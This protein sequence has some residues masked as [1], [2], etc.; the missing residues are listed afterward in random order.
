MII[1]G[2]N[3]GSDGS[4][5]KVFL[6]NSSGRPYQLSVL[7]FSSTSIKVGL[8]G[9]LAGDYKV[10]VNRP[11]IGDFVPAIDGND[12]FSY[13]VTVT[14]VSPA[15]GSINGGSLITIT[16]TNFDTT[17]QQTLVFIGQTINWICSI[18][19]ITSTSIACRVPAISEDYS[20]GVAQD[21]V[22]TTRLVVQ[23]KCEGTCKFTY[24][25]SASSPAISTLSVA[26]GVVTINGTSL[27]AG[28]SCSIV[29]VNS[30]AGTTTVLAATTCAPTSA[31]WTIPTTVASA[32]YQLK[33]R[34]EIGESNAKALT[35]SWSA[36]SADR[37]SGS[38]VGTILKFT[39]G[40]GYP[41]D[42][43]DPAF[44][45]ATVDKLGVATPAKVISCCTSNAL[46]I[47][48]P[49]GSN[50]ASYAVWF[51]GPVK[52][53][54]VGDFV[55]Y[56]NYTATISINSSTTVPAGSNTITLTK[57]NAVSNTITGIQLVSTK[58]PTSIITVSTWTTVNPTTFTFTET[59]PA[60][61][62]SLRITGAIYYFSCTDIL[63]VSAPAPGSLTSS[64]D[65]YSYNGGYYKITGDGLS[66]VSQITVN[67]FVG[68]ISQYTNTEVT[69]RLPAFVTTET[70][71]EYN[72]STVQ[73]LDL[74]TATFFS[75]PLASDASAPTNVSAAF[76]GSI[77]TIY[78][79]LNAACWIGI[80][81]GQGLAVSVNRFRFFPYLS[82][83]NT[84][85]KI[86]DATF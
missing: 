37:W 50:K 52:S 61:S 11:D 35:V 32:N 41:V 49:G 51:Y 21:V 10:K 30:V 17:A 83:T 58:D 66:P 73:Q 65:S 86:L 5:V 12:S 44:S 64:T 79:S 71:S 7:N 9:G 19:T 27:T 53:W 76:D 4:E 20:P 16:G 1:N 74:S 40:S 39:G 54:K 60:G 6:S 67:G 56:D 13:K 72:L 18:E 2:A 28:S 14:A 38:T 43:S 82:W 23:S 63:K 26:S 8:S 47:L 85:N 15:S 45:V 48:A 68:K 75:D 62:Y 33:I 57:T 29:L 34:S 55:P 81:V 25:D 31:T 80:D 70:Q 22:V 36:G 24:L 42:F 84:A 3:F 46:T 77:K 78:G 59:L 69:Y